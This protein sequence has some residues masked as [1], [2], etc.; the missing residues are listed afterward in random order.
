MDEL[1]KAEETFDVL[2]ETDFEH[3]LA[4]VSVAGIGSVTLG[5]MVRVGVPQPPAYTL[6]HTQSNGSPRQ[7]F[8]SES[9]SAA[10]GR[11]AQVVQAMKAQR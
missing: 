1:L 9:F 2:F 11:Y 6:T 7:V 5:C 4:N 3:T 8:I 10:C